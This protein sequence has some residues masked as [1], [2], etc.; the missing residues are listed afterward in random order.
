MT[1]RATGQAVVL[2]ARPLAAASETSDTGR[3]H[4][5]AVPSSGRAR[6]ELRADFR[7]VGPRTEANRT[8]ETGGYRLRMP[9]SHAPQCEAVMVNTGG[10]MAGGD[11]AGFG[12]RC[13]AGTDVTLT[14]TAAEKIYRADGATTRLAVTLDVEA[15][16]RL[17]WLPQET[18][19]FDGADLLR[20]VGVSLAADATLLLGEMLVFGRLA[21]GET[22]RAG[23]LRDSWRVRRAGTLVFAE[24]VALSGD[25]AAT[26]DRAAL[27]AGARAVATL[28]FVSPTAESRL[29]EVRAALSGAGCTAGAS[30][31]NGLLTVRA[32]SASPVLLRAAIVS[33]L[34]L[35]RGRGLPR[36]W[37]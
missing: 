36:L 22:M 31:W 21:M 1:R 12:F 6:G 16:A 4:Q 5:P 30:A 33:V 29:E 23:A 32:L 35:L 26:L 9:R 8:F 15:A 10:G 13:G 34:G 18:I 19:L 2:T 11:Q 20:T 24:E 7:R 25:I 17:D 37:T 28:L 14:S 3:M 27:G